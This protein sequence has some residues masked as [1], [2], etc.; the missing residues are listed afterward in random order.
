MSDGFALPSGSMSIEDLASE[1]AETEPLRL[2]ADRP[3][4][5]ARSAAHG[6]AT[7]SP[8]SLPAAVS[9]I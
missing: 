2:S 6:N 8:L 1:A 9:T 3:V 5:Q 4:V 7:L